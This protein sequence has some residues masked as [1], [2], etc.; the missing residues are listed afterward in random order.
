MHIAPDVLPMHIPSTSIQPATATVVEHIAN[1][2]TARGWL[3]ATAESCTGGLIAAA[4]TDLAGSSRWFDRGFVTYSNTAKT[5]MLGVPAALIA[6]HG[7]VSAPV[8][9]AMAQGAALQAQLRSVCAT[10]AVTGIAG[11][12]GGSVDKPVGTVWF[13]WYVNGHIHS[14]CRQFDGDRSAVRQQTTLH[15]LQRLLML[16]RTDTPADH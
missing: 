13:G 8:A 16:I 2:L 9:Q 15:A 11:P 14:E 10:V 6:T 7:A 1:V 4:C 3:L 5:A 12:D